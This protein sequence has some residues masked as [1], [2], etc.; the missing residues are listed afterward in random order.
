[1]VLTVIVALF[2]GGIFGTVITLAFTFRSF[3]LGYNEG[4]NDSTVRGLVDYDH[5]YAEGLNDALGGVG[6][7]LADNVDLDEIMVIRF[8]DRLPHRYKRIIVDG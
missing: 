5:G 3:N 4:V 8:D 1:M 2:C 6:K 7:I